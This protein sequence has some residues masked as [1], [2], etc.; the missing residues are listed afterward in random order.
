MF[1]C[2]QFHSQTIK[3]HI[4]KAALKRGVETGLQGQELYKSLPRPK[5][6]KEAAIE[7]CSQEE[8]TLVVD[9][10]SGVREPLHYSSFLLLSYAPFRSGTDGG[11]KRYENLMK[12]ARLFYLLVITV[13]LTPSLFILLSL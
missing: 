3:K 10:H 8:G 2:S 6:V 9:A 4:L 13:P 1:T 11:S 5:P 7:D 12:H